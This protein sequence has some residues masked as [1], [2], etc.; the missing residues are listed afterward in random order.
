MNDEFWLSF[1]IWLPCH[2]HL[3][4]VLDMSVGEV[5]LLTSACH[6][7]CLF[8]DPS[9][10]H[11]CLGAFAVVWAVVFICGWLSLF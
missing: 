6:C 5:S 11:I 9:L 4:S 8:V 1:V 3:V 2:C 7:L 10:M